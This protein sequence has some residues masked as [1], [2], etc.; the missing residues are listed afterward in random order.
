MDERGRIFHSNH[1]L[2]EQEGIIDTQMPRDTLQ[3]IE[4][5]E[6]L[7]DDVEGEPT[8]EA[9]LELFKDEQNF[10]TSICRAKGGESKG[11]TLFN[12]VS[13]LNKREALVTVGRPTK[14][15]EQFW[16]RFE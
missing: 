9:V 12:I 5:I 4:R 13:N 1:F 6:Q 11:A 14:P 15:D 8:V 16:L 10:P 2:I 7:A 3:R